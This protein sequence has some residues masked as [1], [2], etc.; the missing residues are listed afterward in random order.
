MVHS[1]KIQYIVVN[2]H[3]VFNSGKETTQ[4]LNTGGVSENMVK[5][6]KYTKSKVF[7][8][9]FKSKGGPA[10]KIQYIIEK[11]QRLWEPT[12]T[13]DFMWL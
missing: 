13:W 9:F 4:S 7:F 10:H 11:L 5:K 2:K 8:F 12:F 3:N 6:K 1:L